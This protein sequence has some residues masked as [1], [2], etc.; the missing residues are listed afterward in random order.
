MTKRPLSNIRQIILHCSDSSWGDAAVIDRWH[1]A[2]GWGG[3]GYHFVILNGFRFANSRYDSFDDGVVETGRSLDT[4]GAHVAGQ[5]ADSIGICLIGRRHF[6]KQQYE[7]LQ[8]LLKDLTR[9]DLPG[10]R[11]VL[12]PHWRYNSSKTC[13]NL[14]MSVLWEG[15]DYSVSANLVW[16]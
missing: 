3:I 14:P 2:R 15:L 10:Q 16:E 6:S 9:K 11:L 7:R 1:K 13:P 5:N 4:V 8:I 12:A